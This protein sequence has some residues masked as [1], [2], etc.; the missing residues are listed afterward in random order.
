MGHWAWEWGMGHWA[1]GMGHGALGMGHGA[2]GMGHWEKS[3]IHNP[4]SQIPR[5]LFL[6]F[7][8]VLGVYP[9]GSRWRVYGG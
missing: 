6:F 4:K 2:W 5:I 9:A 3:S 1:W 8:G 7:L